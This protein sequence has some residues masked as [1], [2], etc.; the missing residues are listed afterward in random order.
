MLPY[1]HSLTANSRIGL[2]AGMKAPCG[3]AMMV[4][5][6]GA[7]KFGDGFCLVSFSAGRAN[8]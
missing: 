6:H 3:V 7:E 4:G 8:A 1:F 5:V 2:L